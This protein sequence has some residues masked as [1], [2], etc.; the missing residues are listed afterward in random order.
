MLKQ[1]YTK[2]KSSKRCIT[3]C[4]VMLVVGVVGTLLLFRGHAAT[5]YISINSSSGSLTNGVSVQSDNNVSGGKYVKFGSTT[6]S[7]YV[8]RSGT[9]L[10]LNGSPYKFVGINFYNANAIYGARLKN[11]GPTMSTVSINPVGDLLDQNLTKM[12][13]TG[14]AAQ[15]MRSW[16][17]ESQATNSSGV[18]DW[19]P[20]DN[21]LAIAKKHGLRIIA[22]LD[23]QW[24]GQCV[25]SGY[26][27]VTWYQSGYKS[28]DGDG[29]LS[30]RNYVQQVV[31][32]YANDPN[33][34]MWQFM[35][36]AQSGDVGGSTCSN[37][38]ASSA[39]LRAWADDIGGL[40]KGIDPN[41]LTSLG[42]G[43]MGGG[44]G[45]KGSDYKTVH[46]SPFVDTCEYHDYNYA[47]IALPSPLV[48]DLDYC[49]KQGLNK[50]LFVGETG[51]VPSIDIGPTG[52]FQNRADLISSKM[53]AQFN[54]SDGLGGSGVVGEAPW[55]W[56]GHASSIGTA[57]F[58]TTTS[59]PPYNSIDFNGPLDPIVGLMVNQ[60]KLGY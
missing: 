57:E 16:F 23:N 34:M 10:T 33:I 38:A 21:T 20:F 48:A 2:C 7:N 26:K 49:G 60:I 56:S 14:T 52:T 50:P 40:I 51:M 18:I 37:E 5:P 3:I 4:L 30:Y 54:Y 36:E 9:T 27:D 6:V 24:A 32:R 44:C 41:H 28:T 25:V 11:C 35:N 42:T 8:Q 29:P 53:Q 45:T 31:T 46:A 17:F 22:T 55:G 47:K 43:G 13:S 39:A 59:I 19:T 15:V 12:N 58:S 1:A